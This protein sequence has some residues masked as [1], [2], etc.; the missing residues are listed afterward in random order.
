MVFDERVTEMPSMVNAASLAL[1]T[2]VAVSE[3]LPVFYG[4]YFITPTA[5][6]DSDVVMRMAFSAPSGDLTISE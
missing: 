3:K 5:A 1:T 4:S 6:P 2:S